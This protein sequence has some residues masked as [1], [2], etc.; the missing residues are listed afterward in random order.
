MTG[1]NLT[2]KASLALFSFVCI[3]TYDKSCNGIVERLSGN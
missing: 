1:S 3:C 2:P